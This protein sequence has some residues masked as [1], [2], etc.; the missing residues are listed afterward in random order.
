MASTDRQRT[1]K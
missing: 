1:K